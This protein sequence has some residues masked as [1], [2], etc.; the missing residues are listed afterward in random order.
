MLGASVLACNGGS[1]ASAAVHHI[2]CWVAL[3]AC[4]S[5]WQGLGVGI[6][7][8]GWQLHVL[9]GSRWALHLGQGALCLSTGWWFPAWGVQ[10]VR[11]CDDEGSTLKCVFVC[12]VS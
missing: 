6:H 1:R 5:I 10:H 9:E 4:L 8:F 12:R 3:V 2:V 11:C 7:P